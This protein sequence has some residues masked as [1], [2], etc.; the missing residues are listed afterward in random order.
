M[1]ACGRRREI[2]GK[3]RRRVHQAGAV[4][5]R[6]HRDEVEVDAGLVTRLLES[7]LPHLA[8]TPLTVVE[9]WGTDH[10]IWRVGADLVVRLP[11][12][13]WAAGQP[14]KEA[15][16]L[17]RLAPHLPVEVPE[18]VA[19]GEPGCGYPY[20]WAVH[21][22]IPGEGAALDRVSDPVQLARDLAEVVRALRTVPIAGAPPARNRARPLADYDVSTRE[23]VERCRPWID[24]DAALAVWEDALAAPAHDGPPTWVQGDLE[25]NC[26]VRDERLCAV[27]DWGSACQGDPA[28][29]VQ[30]AWSPL[31]TDRSR[32]AFLDTVEIDDA[33]IRRARG[34]AVNQ[35]CAALPY[36]QDTYPLIV[37]RSRHKL[38]ALGIAVDDAGPS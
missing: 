23:A 20:Q 15:T 26:L 34:A 8:G 28:V 32:Q 1:D 6:M 2:P 38:T 27:V 4:T 12:I 36:Y 33:T 25:G 17:P 5:P 13:G 11:R 7:Q 18:P 14:A 3:P 22:W 19:L 35:A 21:R 31:F 29:D 37:A 24:V 16:W 30:V 10:A 9:P